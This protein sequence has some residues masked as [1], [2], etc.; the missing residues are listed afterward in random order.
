[1]ESC[2]RRRR[3]WSEKRKRSLAGRKKPRKSH[4]KRDPERA[5]WAEC[6]SA[7]Q[8]TGGDKLLK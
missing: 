4:S 5:R 7:G 8:R 2:W 3:E 6:G 1:M